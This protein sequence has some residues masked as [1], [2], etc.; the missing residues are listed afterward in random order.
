MFNKG[1]DVRNHLSRATKAHLITLQS[2]HPGD[3][4]LKIKDSGPE[5][6]SMNLRPIDEL[7]PM[8]AGTQTQ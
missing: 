2:D 1:S 3:I 4:D 8:N 5:M 7:P 6:G